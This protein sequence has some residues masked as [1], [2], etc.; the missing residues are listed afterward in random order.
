MLSPQDLV[1]SVS[2]GAQDTSCGLCRESVSY[3]GLGTGTQM[4]WHGNI[5]QCVGLLI[6]T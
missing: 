6:H 4:D 3:T 1:L 5:I 2:T